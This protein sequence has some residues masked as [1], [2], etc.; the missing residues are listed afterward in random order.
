MNG[1]QRILLIQ[2]GDIG[3]VVLTAPTAPAILQSWP[4]AQV[5][6]LVFK[7]F[8]VLFKADPNFHRVIEVNRRPQGLVARVSEFWSLVRQLR[9]QRF[10]W[11]ID[12]RTGDRGAILAGISGAKIR[13]GRRLN[14]DHFWRRAL[15]NR[16]LD[17]TPAPT[18]PAH[19]GADQSLRLLRALGIRTTESVPRLYLSQEQMAAR[20]TRLAGL[21]LAPGGYFTASLWS[22]W[23]YKHWHDERWLEL[24]RQLWQKHPYPVLL[25]GDAGQREQAQALAAQ[26]PGQLIPLAGETSLGELPALIAGSRAHLSVDT[27][28]SHMASA[29][30]VPVLTVF[31]P[32]DWRVWK[33]TGPLDRL[34]LNPRFPCQPCN[35]KGCEDSNVSQCLEQLPVSEVMAVLEELLGNEGYARRLAALS[36]NTRA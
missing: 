25:L 17:S 13:V 7:P 1:P 28:A 24:F 21:K 15:F 29:L 12:L 19:P 23:S 36:A 2:T 10:D 20:E 8:G 22:R 18:A 35:R 33:W 34:V 27:A 3:D 4:G 11:A 16:W 31:G 30:E 14:P 26:L 6:L 5:S 9:A 32:S